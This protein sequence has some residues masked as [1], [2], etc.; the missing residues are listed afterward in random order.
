MLFGNQ[1]IEASVLCIPGFREKLQDNFFVNGKTREWL[2]TSIINMVLENPIADGVYAVTSNMDVDVNSG[3]TSLSMVKELKKFKEK[4]ESLGGDLESKMGLLKDQLSEV[5]NYIYSAKLNEPN[6]SFKDEISAACMCLAGDE[7]AITTMGSSKV[8]QYQDGILKQL[9]NKNQKKE[10]LAELGITS[11]DEDNKPKNEIE[12]YPIE[13][14]NSND[15]YVLCCGAATQYLSERKLL[16][17]LSTN[18]ETTTI[19]SELLKLGVVENEQDDL[20]ILIVR[21]NQISAPGGHAVIKKAAKKHENADVDYEDEDYYDDDYD[22]NS[23]VNY[24]AI[25]AAA[26]ACLIALLIGIAI[27]YLVL[28]NLFDSNADNPPAITETVQPTEETL[29]QET[30]ET[31]EE[32]T[33]VSTKAPT[34]APTAAPTKAPKPTATPTPEVKA[35]ADADG[36]ITHI[37][38]SGDNL[39]NISIK[40]YGKYLEQKLLDANPGLEPTKMKVGDKV[41][42]PPEE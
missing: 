19:A 37:V 36:N 41:I 14:L 9:T 15:T 35:T 8:F 28:P 13:K 29:P 12:T 1:K 23:R 24:S 34:K 27:G 22:D 5:S 32:P 2:D 18:M 25:F 4:Y 10:H 38:K 3:A 31:T 39:Y 16:E 26:F 20:S 7:F 21:L 11:M 6:L 42:I 30:E 40:Y 33:E 17:L